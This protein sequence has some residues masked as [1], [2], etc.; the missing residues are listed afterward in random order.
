MTRKEIF[1]AAHA[2]AKSKKAELNIAYRIALSSALIEV[3]N[4]AKQPKNMNIQEI[5]EKVFSSSEEGNKALIATG[6]VF[7]GKTSDKRGRRNFNIFTDEKK[8]IDYHVSYDVVNGGLKV[9]MKDV[10]DQL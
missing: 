4:S 6:L 3:Y 2:L 5:Q 1:I 9:S 8:M 10:T 7:Y